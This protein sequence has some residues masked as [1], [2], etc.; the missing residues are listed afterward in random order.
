MNEEMN[1][2]GGG[3][4]CACKHHMVKPWAFIAI[5]VL[6]TLMGV[7]L[8][9]GM[10]PIFISGILFIVMGVMKIKKCKCCDNTCSC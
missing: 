1:Q 3:K 4:T 9:R 7:G 10:W 8:F 6:F 5:G 2:M